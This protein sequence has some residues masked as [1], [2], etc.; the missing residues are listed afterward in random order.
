MLAEI[1]RSDIDLYSEASLL[2]PYD[3][4]R[5]LR[6]LGPVVHLDKLDMFVAARYKDVKDVLA[7]PE[8]FIS[9]E[10]V[11]MNPVVNKAL[12]GIG[13]CSDGDEHRRIR[14][15]EA[16][17][18]NPRALRELR[19]TITAEAETVVAR[20]ITRKSFDAVTDLAQYLPLSIVSNLVGLPEEGRER[21][22]IWAAGNFDS[23]GPPTER[24]MRSMGVFEEMVSYAMTPVRSGQAQARGMGGDAARRGRGRRDQRSGSPADCDLLHGPVA[25]YDDLRDFERD[26]AVRAQSRSMDA[27][28]REPQADPRRDQRGAAA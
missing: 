18:L 4:Y 12:Q 1:S 16:R 23:F 27:A 2:A 7:T 9:G 21:M 22:L 8:V 19:D 24:A 20:L 10:G 15:V 25:G 13:L 17:P 11:T 28:A 14:K 6:D 5:E 3:N 26:L